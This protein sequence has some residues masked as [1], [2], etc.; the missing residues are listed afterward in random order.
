MV[1]ARRGPIPLASDTRIR[2]RFVAL[3]DAIADGP[4]MSFA[5][6]GYWEAMHDTMA[7]YY[8]VRVDS[9]DTHYRLFC[10]LERN[11]AR[12]GLAGPSVVIVDGRTKAFRTT[13]SEGDYAEVRKLGSEYLS[14]SPR[15]ILG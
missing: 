9:K 4:P 8:E 2:A 10:L 3:L 5:G 6:G 1:L 12:V 13:L 7:G 11:G 14:R 15:S